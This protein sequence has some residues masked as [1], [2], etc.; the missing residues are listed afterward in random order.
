MNSRCVLPFQISHSWMIQ[1][2][3][4]LLSKSEEHMMDVTLEISVW[5]SPFTYILHRQYAPNW[6]NILGYNATPLTIFEFEEVSIITHLRA[7]DGA[8]D[9]LR[10][11]QAY[12][13]PSWRKH[14]TLRLHFSCIIVTL[15]SPF[16]F[17]SH[18]AYL[19]TCLVMALPDGI[20]LVFFH[21]HI[22]LF[23]CIQ[24]STMDLISRTASTIPTLR[25]SFHSP[26]RVIPLDLRWSTFF[27]SLKGF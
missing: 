15:T 26:F 27:C 14:F 13:R 23:F 16:F 21:F 20:W 11:K 18:D 1:P 5:V 3:R 9:A 4:T 12:V 19:S 7:L 10:N 6:L 24:F 25:H 22:T 17:R 8:H 2:D